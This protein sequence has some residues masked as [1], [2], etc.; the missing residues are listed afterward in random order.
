VHPSVVAELRQLFPQ[1]AE[2]ARNAVDV[3]VDT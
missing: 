1:A 2:A 3:A